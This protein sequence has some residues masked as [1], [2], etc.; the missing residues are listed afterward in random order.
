[1]VWWFLTVR[2]SVASQNGRLLTFVQTCEVV[3]HDP[4]EDAETRAVP[5]LGV[6]SFTPLLV[7]LLL[8][9]SREVGGR[10]RTCIVALLSRIR[11]A[12]E[13][14]T[15]TG[16][17]GPQQRRMFEREIM[18]QVVIGMAHL[19]NAS[20]GPGDAALE[21]PISPQPPS[22]ADDILLLPTCNSASLATS[23]CVAMNEQVHIAA[24]IPRPPSPLPTSPILSPLR[25]HGRDPD[26]T[27]ALADEH[28]VAHFK[29]D[30]TPLPS[31]D[32][33]S[34]SSATGLQS[35]SS[36]SGS[37]SLQPLQDVDGA[38]DVSEEQN[39]FGRVASMSLIAT[40]TSS[41]R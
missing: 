1:M 28:T 8:N 35:Q 14:G 2:F 40:V 15:S 22:A 30:Q 20:S 19:D 12:N 9:P 16:H 25:F 24:P 5:L 10:A 31:S 29:L 37:D 27:P 13:N 4:S 18:Q 6:Q 39:A 3:D 17:F 11:D 41:G 36:N 38:Q 21:L 34:S 23:H 32:V 26:L 33:A 7:T